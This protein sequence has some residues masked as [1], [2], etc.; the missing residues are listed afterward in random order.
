L[1]QTKV[2][3]HKVNLKKFNCVPINFE[4]FEMEKKNE[5]FKGKLKMLACNTKSDK[6]SDRN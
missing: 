3:K 5:N 6:T 4:K 1:S 2:V